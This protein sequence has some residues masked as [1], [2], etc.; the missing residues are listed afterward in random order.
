MFNAQLTTPAPVSS[1]LEIDPKPG[2]CKFC[3][4][5]LY[6]VARGNSEELYCQVCRERQ[7]DSSRW[8]SSRRLEPGEV[9][10]RPRYLRQG[11]EKADHELTLAELVRRYSRQ[12]K[13]LPRTYTIT[14]SRPQL[15]QEEGKELCYRLESEVRTISG[16]TKRAQWQA[17]YEQGTLFLQ[18]AAFLEEISYL[19]ETIVQSGKECKCY[20]LRLVLL[21]EL[22]NGFA[23]Q[24]LAN[25]YL[26]PNVNI[27]LKDK[28]KPLYLPLSELLSRFKSWEVK[29]IDS[30]K[31]VLPKPESKASSQATG[32]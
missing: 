1:K 5:P 11:W 10:P 9:I 24:S 8:T 4:G 7:W 13:L 29:V 2:Q 17:T 3:Y 28:Y 32:F 30:P 31:A 12:P 15:I 26:H 20:T 23:Y 18:Y 14:L 21:D 16:K 27:G 25:K 6:L 19:V 22:E